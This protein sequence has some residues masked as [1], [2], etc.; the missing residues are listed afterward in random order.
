MLAFEAAMKGFQP[1]EPGL[2]VLLHINSETKEV[3]P[4]VPGAV[5]L[6][7]SLGWRFATLEECLRQ[8]D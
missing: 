2:I 6:A 8:D 5:A 7:R 3:A 4:L 1:T